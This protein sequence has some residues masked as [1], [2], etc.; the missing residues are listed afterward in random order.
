M[1]RKQN[2]SETKTETKTY[3]QSGEIGFGSKGEQL[4]SSPLGSCVAVM[5]Y[6]IKL[7]IGGMAHLMLPGKSLKNNNHDKNKY[8]FNAINCLLSQ[9]YARGARDS[10]IEICLT[11]GANV[12]KNKN[13]TISSDVIES[14]LEIF[15]KKKLKI[16][17]KSLGGFE[18]RSAR[19]DLNTGIVYFTI[20]ESAEK[21]LWKYGG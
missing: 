2:I 18:R 5:A 16:R 21:V 14:V 4:I 17:A 9:L 8:A 10:N 15:D 1:F 7:K 3:I 11:G 6:D 12:L 19:L 20:G 13:D